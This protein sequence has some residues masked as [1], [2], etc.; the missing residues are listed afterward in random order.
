MDEISRSALHN[1]SKYLK[2]LGIVS[3]SMRLQ[4]HV[5]I[6]TQLCTQMA[7]NVQFPLAVYSWRQERTRSLTENERSQL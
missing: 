3:R 7:R 4:D 5:D 1:I 6:A 2:L